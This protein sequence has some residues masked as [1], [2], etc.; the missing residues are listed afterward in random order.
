MTISKEIVKDPVALRKWKIITYDFI[1]TAA[2]RLKIDKILNEHE[3]EY[4]ILHTLEIWSTCEA[5]NATVGRLVQIL[6]SQDLNMLK[7]IK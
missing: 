1:H 7:V 6:K 3:Y 5:E 2:D 4:A